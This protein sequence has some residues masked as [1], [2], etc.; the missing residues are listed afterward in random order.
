M[1]EKD[2]REKLNQE[3]EEMAPDMLSKILQTPIE[4]VKSEKELFG[5]NRPLFKEKKNY[6]QY[7]IAPAI[8][9]VAACIVLAIMLWHPTM[10]PK[11]TNVA[12]NIIIDVNP[13]INIAIKQDGTIKEIV[14]ENKDAKPIVKQVNEKIDENTDYKK[15]VKQVVKSLKKNGYLKKKKNAMLLSVVSEDKEKVKDQMT[16]IK[17]TTN[18]VLEEKEIRC[19]TLYQNCEIN[20]KVEKVAKK[21]HVSVGKATLCIK[22]AEK[23]NTSVK[24]MCKK[25]I[26]T[27]VKEVEKNVPLDLNKITIEDDLENFETESIPYETESFEESESNEW[28]TIENMTEEE[29]TGENISLPNE[30]ESETIEVSVETPTSI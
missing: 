16:L 22:L 17:T 23:E 4:P 27:L 14:A 1:Q 9:A 24:K 25:N 8:V 3:L 28:E 15:A 7:F 19:K 11:N 18:Q 21:N 6:K 30:G 5:R 2:I 10:T 20:D 12:F 13:S 26:D 29:E